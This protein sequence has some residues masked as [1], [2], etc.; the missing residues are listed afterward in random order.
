[1]NSIFFLGDYYR[2]LRPPELPASYWVSPNPPLLAQLSVATCGSGSGAPKPGYADTRCSLSSDSGCLDIT[3]NTCCHKSLLDDV[4]QQIF[5]LAYCLLVVLLSWKHVW[6]Q[7]KR[8]QPIFCWSDENI[9]KAESGGWH[10]LDAPFASITRWKEVLCNIIRRRA[11]SIL[12]WNSRQA[13]LFKWLIKWHFF[14]CA[15]KGINFLSESFLKSFVKICKFWF[16]HQSHQA[17]TRNMWPSGEREV[18]TRKLG[19]KS[20]DPSLLA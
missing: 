12:N 13:D 14:C 19:V 7:E 18:V 5:S 8:K 1:M 10:T 16:S 2:T 20:T 15:K 4:S 6:F 9:Y 3:T 11:G 17:W